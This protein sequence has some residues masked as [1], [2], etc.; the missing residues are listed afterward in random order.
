MSL[1]ALY[2]LTAELAEVQRILADPETDA[3]EWTD[4]L[5]GLSGAVEQK[6]TNVAKF[7]RNLEALVA[8][9][10]QEEVRFVTR[11]R[12]LEKR[13]KGMQE[14]LKRNLESVGI[15]QV[16]SPTFTVSVR[17]NPPAV[18]ILDAGQ[19]PEEFLVRPP[20][21]EPR[22]DKLAIRAAIQ[23]GREVPGAALEQTTR[24]EIK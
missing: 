21:P 2:H 17:T 10:K 18:V 24:L 3:Q 14:Y 13:I 6:A 23:A 7:V 12:L 4:T 15:K 5:E 11:R 19:I 1:P 20:P 8:A 9:L 16:Q 22:I